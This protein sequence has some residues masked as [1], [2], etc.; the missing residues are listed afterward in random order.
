AAATPGARSL[1]AAGTAAELSSENGSFFVSLG[2]DPQFILTTPPNIQGALKL[3][4]SLRVSPTPKPVSEIVN[5]LF[6]AA[7]FER[8]TIVNELREAITE[9][10]RTQE[11]LLVAESEL[12][13]EQTTRIAME[14]SL[15]WIWTAPIRSL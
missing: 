9:K 10:K 14:Q 7:R 3:T 8:D 11:L 2:D 5:S 4:I 1:V 12:R 6:N 15:S 13:R